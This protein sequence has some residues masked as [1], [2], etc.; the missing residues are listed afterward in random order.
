MNKYFK[1]ILACLL[2]C[3]LTVSSRAATTTIIAYG[4]DQ[5]YSGPLHLMTVNSQIEGDFY[6]RTD[7]DI[8]YSWEVSGQDDEGNDILEEIAN[9]SNPRNIYRVTLPDD[10]LGRS[11]SVSWDGAYTWT[12][13]RPF[14]VDDGFL[15]YVSGDGGSP[16][17]PVENPA[18]SATV[19]GNNVLIGKWWD[20]PSNVLFTLNT[21]DTGDPAWPAIGMDFIASSRDVFWRWLHPGQNP[22]RAEIAMD[23]D[24]LHRLTLHQ[25]G[26]A[27]RRIVIDPQVGQI[28]IDGQPLMANTAPVGSHMVNLGYHTTVQG[29]GQT[30]VGINNLAVGNATSPTDPAS[31]VFVV[32]SGTYGV[33]GVTNQARNA[34]T[35]QRNGDTRVTG[36]LVIGMG[37]SLG[38]VASNTGQLVLGKYN[39]K[40][41]DDGAPLHTDHTRG[42]LIIGNGSNAA[43]AN[44]LRV[45]EDGNI[46]IP[47][48][49]DISMG[50]FTGGPK[51]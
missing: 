38:A 7:W 24:Y 32:G 48:Q 12:S 34:F 51:P 46:L 5:T 2:S 3:A 9:Y 35:V 47:P 8:S 27:T 16:G 42:L 14:L 37:N 21:W 1:P 49:G 18:A 25:R 11:I 31:A 36:G 44:A 4:I 20:P 33:E 19:E 15:S 40:R 41:S 23:L 29:Y 28:T 10:W 6:L 17:H 30:V 13:F 26:S 50:P 22:N 43:A 45:A 39:D